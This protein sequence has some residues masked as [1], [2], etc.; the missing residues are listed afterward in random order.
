MRSRLRPSRAGAVLLLWT[1]LLA[2]GVASGPCRAG[3]QQPETPQYVDGTYLPAAPPEFRSTAPAPDFGAATPA[4]VLSSINRVWNACKGLKWVSHE[5]IETVHARIDRAVS[6]VIAALPYRPSED[7]AAILRSAGNLTFVAVNMAYG[8]GAMPDAWKSTKPGYSYGYYIKTG[9]HAYASG[10]AQAILDQ[11]ELKG[12]CKDYAD[13]SMALDHLS[14]LRSFNA[15]CTCRASTETT[16]DPEAERIKGSSA[17]NRGHAQEGLWLLTKYGKG[18]P[19][20][21]RALDARA[22]AWVL[23]DP[24]AVASAIRSAPV[25]RL[26]VFPAPRAAFMHAA[27]PFLALSAYMRVWTTMSR[28]GYG[29]GYPG[30]GM[31]KTG[32]A[33]FDDAKKVA[34]MRCPPALMEQERQYEALYAAIRSG[35]TEEELIAAARGQR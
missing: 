33:G 20:A 12:V 9:R 4:D 16:F 19:E 8:K 13:L 31:A 27:S 3:A 18:L 7:H 1:V 29:A 11:P 32:I 2:A 10:L 30:F 26:R 24:T 23:N 35:K 25:S 34:A 17:T 21:R 14:G 15:G 28:F 22:Y 5:P 6:A